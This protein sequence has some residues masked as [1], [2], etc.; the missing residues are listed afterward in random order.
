ME[1]IGESAFSLVESLSMPYYALG[2][3]RKTTR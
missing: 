3:E 2:L 1:L